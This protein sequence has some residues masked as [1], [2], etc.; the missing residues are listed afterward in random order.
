MLVALCVIYAGGWA[1]LA[2]LTNP[3]TAFEVGVAP[4]VIADIIKVAFGAAL[5]PLAQRY[6]T[7][8]V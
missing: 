2:V 7:R 5:L 6:V 8:S 1:W 4:F 3:R